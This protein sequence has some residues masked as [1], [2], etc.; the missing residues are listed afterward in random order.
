MISAVRDSRWLVGT[1]EIA[2][3][4]GDLA[5][6]LRANGLQVTTA[7]CMGQEAFAH[8][9]YDTVVGRAVREVSWPALARRLL[10]GKRAPPRTKDP[11]SRL[12]HLIRDHDVFVFVHSSLWHDHQRVP[13]RFGMGREFSLLKRLGK[14]IVCFLNGPDV[15]HPSAYD[16]ELAILDIPAAPLGSLLRGWKKDPLSR[17]LRNLRRIE[18]WSDAIFSQP[19]QLRWRCGR[20]ITGSR[21]LRRRLIAHM[22]RGARCR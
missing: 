16:Q 15:R 13:H 3:F 9:E 12:Y 11:L 22:Y 5:A 21:P 7:M 17:P 6:G 14:R 10:Q 1:F 8:I 18:H 4:C 19:N 20:I 2:G